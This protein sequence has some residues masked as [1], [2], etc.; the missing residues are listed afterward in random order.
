MDAE[1]GPS[2]D[3][4]AVARCKLAGQ[5]NPPSYRDTRIDVYAY[6]VRVAGLVILVDSGIGAGN[7]SR[8]G[9]ENS[10]HERE[11]DSNRLVLA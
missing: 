7:V 10:R 1:N 3:R 8:I 4:L 9:R 5:F 6:L 11:G 2:I